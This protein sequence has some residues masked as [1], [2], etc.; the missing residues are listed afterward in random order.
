MPE[1]QT[2]LKPFFWILGTMPG[3]VIACLNSV[4][5]NHCL[6][7]CY[8][9][10]KYLAVSTYRCEMQLGHI[11][12]VKGKK[13]LVKWGV[14]NQDLVASGY[15]WI[16]GCLFFITRITNKTKSETCGVGDRLTLVVSLI[17]WMEDNSPA[18]Q[19]NLLSIDD[20]P[21]EVEGILSACVAW[22]P[23]QHSSQV[24]S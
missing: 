1:L 12:L 20:V 16:R 14:D 3:K 7:R 15:R 17:L 4:L 5:Q 8:L 2:T 21:Q 24:V 9:D 23:A 13:T 11:C 6:R 19:T 10:D 22:A 18:V